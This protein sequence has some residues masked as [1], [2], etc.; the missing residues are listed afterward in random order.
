MREKV[1]VPL[2]RS[3]ATME[4][5]ARIR[6][7]V[8]EIENL[9]EETDGGLFSSGMAVKDL[10]ALQVN[11]RRALSCATNAAST[12]GASEYINAPGWKQT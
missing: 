5:I 10:E 6:R 4:D 3:N 11:L 7:V 9:L 12:L 8:G 2:P 1:L